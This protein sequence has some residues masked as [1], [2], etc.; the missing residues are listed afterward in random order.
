MFAPDTFAFTYS[1][2]RRRDYQ[3][4][5][6]T[7]NDGG[8]PEFPDLS[9]TALTVLVVTG[10][11]GFIL[12]S[13]LQ[14]PLKLLL[15]LTVV[16]EPPAV[17]LAL[18]DDTPHIVSQGKDRTFITSSIRGTLRHLRHEG[19]FWA[20][21]RGIVPNF[22]FFI[23]NAIVQSVFIGIMAAIFPH[24]L[25]TFL[26]GILAMVAMSRFALLCTHVMIAA[27]LQHSWLTQLKKTSWDQAKKTFPA[28]LTF[29]AALQ[30]NV[31]VALIAKSPS[32]PN[33]LR[34]SIVGIGFLAYIL[35]T[36]PATILLIRVQAS[37]LPDDVPTI[38]QFDK[39]FGQDT[40]ATGG[41]LTLT[42]AFKSFDIALFKR[43]FI[44]IL[45]TVPITVFAT[46]ALIALLFAEF[47]LFQS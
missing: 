13:L 14:Y 17:Y 7:D 20:P 28:L 22:C 6:Y 38:V 43:L 26:G 12:I 36:I 15:T 41:Y 21:W 1:A 19:G 31:E 24:R 46:L 32:M 5:A 44:F 23:A 10:V 2:I 35:I 30:L 16:E 25:A 8:Q 34:F 3:V 4:Y 42:Q 40:S 18:E 27:P 29:A 45:K 11:I 39:T 33:A 37:V 47:Y 9:R